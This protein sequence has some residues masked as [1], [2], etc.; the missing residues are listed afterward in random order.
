MKLSLEKGTWLDCT[1]SAAVS[2]QAVLVGVTGAHGTWR[3][4]SPPDAPVPSEPGGAENGDT[5]FC[6]E[7]ISFGLSMA[8]P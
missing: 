1:L 3:C 8:G 2:L 4:G 7:Q 6:R 5:V